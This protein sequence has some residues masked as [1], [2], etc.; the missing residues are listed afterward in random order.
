MKALLGRECWRA[1]S[2]ALSLSVCTVALNGIRAE[3]RV[4][5]ADGASVQ[6]VDRSNL[7]E[8]HLE[9]EARQG[10][11]M[12][13]TVPSGTIALE[14]DGAPIAFAK[15]GRFLIA[16]DRDAP[17]TEI[18][19]ANLADGKTVER[20]IHVQPGRWRIEQVDTSPTADVPTA[21]FLAR[22][23]LEL[24]RIMAA[25]A[26]QV[27]SDGWRQNF[28]WPLAGR[29]SGLFGSQRI[30]QGVPGS[31]H[32]GVDIAARSG[33]TFVA[34]ADGVVVLAAE[35]PFTLEG[36][37]LIV[38]H[39]MGLNSAFLHCSSLAVSEG[40]VVRQGQVLGTVGS[41]G[42]ATGPHLHWGV[43]WN[44]ARLDPVSLAGPMQR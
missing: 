9:G 42:R 4:V 16:F 43:K 39:G 7:D 3:A 24:E 17:E 37:L 32:S 5:A 15:D 41:T 31:Y 10:G 27:Y 13:G 2:I 22:R 18:L 12:R 35:N 21:E 1:T 38:A 40:D 23:K 25:R 19:I 20:H 11:F 34:P 33:T 6:S 26:V 14:F 29:V 44:N 30:Y 36:H 8:F 28:H